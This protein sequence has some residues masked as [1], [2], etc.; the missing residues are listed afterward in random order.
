SIGVVPF[1]LFDKVKSRCIRVPDHFRQRHLLRQGFPF[2]RY[3]LVRAAYRTSKYKGEEDIY[4][5]HRLRFVIPFYL[6]MRN[7]SMSTN[8]ESF[9]WESRVQNRPTFAPIHFPG[10][11]WNV[12]PTTLKLLPSML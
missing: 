2:R 3:P 7:H 11:A 8:P 5:S 12:S 4:Y 9:V 6:V 10:T 1:R